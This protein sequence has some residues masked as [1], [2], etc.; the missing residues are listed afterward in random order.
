MWSFCGGT[1]VNVVVAGWRG[2]CEFSWIVQGRGA[3]EG[4]E[5][6]FWGAW[7]AVLLVACQYDPRKQ[8]Q[9]RGIAKSLGSSKHNGEVK[10]VVQEDASVAA[11]VE[12]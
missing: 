3:G 5:E 1:F 2:R 6:S 12:L 9:N 10:V 4:S 7:I 8:C 11:A